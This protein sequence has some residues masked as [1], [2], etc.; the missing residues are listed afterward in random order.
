MILKKFIDFILKP[1][2]DITTV[3]QI[4]ILNNKHIDSNSPEALKI[5]KAMAKA[6]ETLSHASKALEEASKTLDEI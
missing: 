1:L 3:K 4:Y 6:S 5:N 2:R